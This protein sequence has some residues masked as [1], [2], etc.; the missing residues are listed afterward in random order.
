VV[1][2]LKRV[3]QREMREHKDSAAQAQRRVLLCSRL[4]STGDASLVE[5]L[6]EVLMEQCTEPK[7]Q[8][9]LQEVV[10]HPTHRDVQ[11]L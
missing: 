10:N 9:E 2:C 8:A 3:L 4:W 5:P 6:L 1:R 11:E 7:L